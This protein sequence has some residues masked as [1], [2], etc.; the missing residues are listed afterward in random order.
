MF[1]AEGQAISAANYMIPSQPEVAVADGA[2]AL[3]DITL[4]DY[5][6]DDVAA[7]G[8]DVLDQFV[9]RYLNS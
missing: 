1:S 7:N 8:A 2:K 9:E 3:S 6:L 5:D 4:L